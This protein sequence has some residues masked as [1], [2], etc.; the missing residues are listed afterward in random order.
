MPGVVGMPCEYCKCP[1]ELFRQHQAGKLVG[2]RHPSEGQG[3]LRAPQRSARPAAR[4]SDGE[5]DRLLA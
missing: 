3:G 2:Q 4:R 5:D 1:V